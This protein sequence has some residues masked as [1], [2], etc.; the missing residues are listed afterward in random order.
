MKSF[1]LEAQS[2]SLDGVKQIETDLP[3]PGP[4]QV[5]VKMKA[6][7]LNFRDLAIVAGQYFGGPVQKDTVLLSDGAGEVERA[8]EGV[9]R[10]QSGDR[11]AGTFFEDLIDGPANPMA[12]PALGHSAEGVLTQ[13]RLFHEDNLVSIPDALSFEEGACLPCAG[14][15][16][17][18]AVM[19][20]GNPVNADSTVLALGT[21]GVS[22]F[23]LQFAKAAGAKVII[24]SSSDDKLAKAKDL[25]ADE[26]INYKTHPDWEEEVRNLTA[27]KGVDCVVE[28]GGI[29]TIN[30]SIASL[31]AGG[32]IGMIGVL[33]GNEGDC[34]PRMLMMTGSSIHGIFVGNRSMF[35]RMNQF[36]TEHDLH[37]QIDKVFDFDDSVDAIKYFQSQAHMGKVVIR[38]DG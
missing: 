28:V 8:G 33:A 24:T 10:F 7:S 14:V 12:N 4:G 30:R 32:K 22:M 2:T 20:A 6:A 5:L 27:G 15:T 35:E 23:A 11:V 38:I 18:H 17:W 34:N 1:V 13:Y 9:S 21:G 36:I 3:S 29:G 37:P 16:A 31:G 26:G 19:E 25:G